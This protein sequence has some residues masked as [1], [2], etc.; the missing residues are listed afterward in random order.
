MIFTRKP[1]QL[2]RI[3]RAR[4]EVPVINVGGWPPLAPVIAESPVVDSF[5][6]RFAGI[7][8][9]ARDVTNNDERN[10]ITRGETLLTIFGRRKLEYFSFLNFIF[11]GCVNLY[12]NR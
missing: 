11:V 9:F 1:A 7:A 4:F 3:V 2:F 10:R 6:I 8:R 5:G 12:S